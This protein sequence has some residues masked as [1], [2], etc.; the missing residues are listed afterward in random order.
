M[1]KLDHGGG[2]GGG[3][4]AGGKKGAGGS[5]EE[6]SMEGTVDERQSHLGRWGYSLIDDALSVSTKQAQCG[7]DRSAGVEIALLF[8]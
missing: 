4:G 7:L 5:R 8:Y 3:G 2:G 1:Y 6:E